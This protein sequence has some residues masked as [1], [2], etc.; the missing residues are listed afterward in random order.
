MFRFDEKLRAVLEA[1]RKGKLAPFLM[2]DPGIGKSSF[3][4]AYAADVLCSK[5]FTVNCNTLGDRTDL[6]GVRT[7]MDPKPMQVFFPHVTIQEC[8][9]YANAH[10]NE[11]VT[12]FLDEINRVSAD[13]TSALLSLITART[14][15]N[16]PIPDNVFIIAAGND[17]GNIVAFDDASTTR[18]IMLHTAPDLDTFFRVNPNLHPAIKAVL[19]RNPSLLT[20]RRLMN[21]ATEE[22]DTEEVSF[23]DIF[24]DATPMVQKTAP[25]TITAA[26]RMLRGLSDEFLK[27]AM[28][29]ITMSE[30]EPDKEISELQALLESV[31]GPTQFTVDVVNEL[32]TSMASGST[33]NGSTVQRP[34]CY[35]TIMSASTVT[36]A[37]NYVKTLSDTEKLAALTYAI[38][39]NE[40][41]IAIVNMLLA[42]CPANIT[43][44]VR[45]T[46]SR[47]IAMG[48]CSPDIMRALTSSNTILAN[49]ARVLS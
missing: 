36:D 3:V 15:G 40:S 16:W 26:D 25:R 10:P 32:M 29:S 4:E 44:D 8:I 31:T 38:D 48:R 21:T 30:Y 23:D 19:T 5:C 24:S 20:A 2:G 39:S 22:D 47:I 41:Q 33:V 6:T 27:N 1:A 37:E 46:V 28:Y 45:Q 11:N 49:I 13:I 7:V 42:N 35:D 34:V 18:F 12:L 43:D 14:I 9:E 17:K